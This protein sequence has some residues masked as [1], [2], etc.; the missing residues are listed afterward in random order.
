LIALSNEAGDG[1]SS[2]LRPIDFLSIDLNADM[3]VLS[4]C[5]TGRLSSR[6]GFEGMTSSLMISGVPS[7]IASLWNVDDEVTASLMESFYTY[8]K[9]G[10]RKGEALRRAKLDMIK[11]GRSDP[12]YWGAFILCGDGDKISI[13]DSRSD[14]AGTSVLISAI[15]GFS[16]ACILWIIVGRNRHRMVRIPFYH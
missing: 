7:V 10:V 8:L 4:G 15:V 12:F 9:N 2:G 5:N 13:A 16:A 11:T 3:V 14:L 6:S 1:G